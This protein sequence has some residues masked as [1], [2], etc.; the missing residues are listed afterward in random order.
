MRT[1]TPSPSITRSRARARRS[2][3]ARWTHL[4]GDG[5]STGLAGAIGSRGRDVVATGW[6]GSAGR[7]GAG[8]GVDAGS[9]VLTVSRSGRE[10][11]VCVAG[12]PDTASASSS[13]PSAETPF[14]CRAVPEDASGAGPSFGSAAT[15]WVAGPADGSEAVAPLGTPTAASVNSGGP[16]ARR[17]LHIVEEGAGKKGVLNRVVRAWRSA[18]DQLGCKLTTAV[19]P[20]IRGRDDGLVLIPATVA[21]ETRE[22]KRVKRNA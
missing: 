13:V 15:A 1:I 17:I 2:P 19:P 22:E 18:S 5:R 11:T 16:G 9:V 14:V 12:P 20:A 4:R 8:A 10:P 21:R 7:S 3:S 6:G